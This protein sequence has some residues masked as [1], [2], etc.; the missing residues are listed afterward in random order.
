MP[1]NTSLWTTL[2]ED[3][4]STLSAEALM[5]IR[6]ELL[7]YIA[8]LHNVE[9]FQQE[10]MTYPSV[11][12]T[13][14]QPV[15]LAVTRTP[16][17]ITYAY[18]YPIDWTTLLIKK[19]YQTM[20]PVPEELLSTMTEHQRN[21]RYTRAKYNIATVRINMHRALNNNV[22]QYRIYEYQNGNKE[23]I[24]YA[25]NVYTKLG[26]KFT[27]YRT[28]EIKYVN[29]YRAGQFAAAE[30]IL[31]LLCKLYDEVFNFINDTNMPTTTKSEWIGDRLRC[32]TRLPMHK[33][34][35]GN[36]SSSHNEN[37]LP[38]TV[39]AH[40]FH[41][42]HAKGYTEEHIGLVAY[43]R[44]KS[45]A[46]WGRITTTSIEKYLTEFFS[47]LISAADIKEIGN[48]FRATGVYN[49]NFVEN[50]DP[51][52]AWIEV[53]DK[54]PSSCMKGHSAVSI[55]A[56]P[57]N[58]LRLAYLT[59]GNNTIVARAIVR[60]GSEEMHGY[61]RIYPEPQNYPKGK[62]LKKLLAATGYTNCTCLEGV[63]VRAEEVEEDVYVMPYLDNGTSPYNI[64]AVL[65]GLNLMLTSTGNICC[66]R[67]YGVASHD[68]ALV[69]A[70]NED[71]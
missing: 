13:I 39:D 71:N 16:Q 27:A 59:D 33:L 29:L 2:R 56:Y 30:A 65:C 55:Y 57:G 21:I 5:A 66:K 11:E 17:Q 50:T 62:I 45:A 40:P 61:I 34:R 37:I 26:I 4:P 41:A 44:T 8:P 12:L 48:N 60:D 47:N 3:A 1:I 35:V 14:P 23:N 18:D 24:N 32:N 69:E 6:A 54:G 53:Y 9:Q 38:I 7:S 64:A 49:L 70:Y 20:K 10:F 28:T 51:G 42:V 43:Y 46:L 25:K 58:G 31:P 68:D 67:T 19:E 15:H 52:D 36:T 22:A 63:L